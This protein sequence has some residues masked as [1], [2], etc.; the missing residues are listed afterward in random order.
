MELRRCGAH[1][2]D[3]VYSDLA[4]QFPPAECKPEKL[5]KQLI[6]QKKYDL[7]LAYDNEVA[8][9]YLLL[10]PTPQKTVWL[11]YIAVFPEKHSHGYGSQM[12]RQLPSVYPSYAGCLLEVEQ[13]DSHAPN[14]LRRIRFYESL[15]C[16]KY[17]F[18][19]ALPT[20]EGSFQMDLYLLPWQLAPLSPD[21]VKGS[22]RHAF[23]TIHQDIGHREQIYQRILK[24]MA[25]NSF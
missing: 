10:C 4:R 8:V 18:Y 21:A 11:D 15:G 25:E 22:I 3:L 2:L 1:M 7:I 6:A 16:R 12:L 23:D 13:A 14:T 19:Y 24:S 5:L 9:G 20:P 17:P